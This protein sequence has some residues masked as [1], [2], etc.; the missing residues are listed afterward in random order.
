MEQV[1]VSN[2]ETD[3]EKVMDIHNYIL[4]PKSIKIC[5]LLQQDVNADYHMNQIKSD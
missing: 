5:H 2:T 3:K 4:K 1:E